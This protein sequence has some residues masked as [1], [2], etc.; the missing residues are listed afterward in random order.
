LLPTHNWMVAPQK[1]VCTPEAF[2]VPEGLRYASTM[3][4]SCAVNSDSF[5]YVL[6]IAQALSGAEDDMPLDYLPYPYHPEDEPEKPP[7]K[8]GGKN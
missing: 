7:H 5:R 2:P 1:E 3:L 4:F 6:T 8:S